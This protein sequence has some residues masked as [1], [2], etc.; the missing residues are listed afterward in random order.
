M[1]LSEQVK[2]IS[3]LKNN[4]SKVFKEVRE[5]REPYFITQNGEAKV[6]VQDIRDYEKNQETLALLKILAHSKKQ[7]AEGKIID[8]DVAFRELREELN[9][10]E[11]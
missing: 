8:A 1:K 10:D 3:Y 7:I 4:T 9:S 2:P 11:D 6:V 5:K